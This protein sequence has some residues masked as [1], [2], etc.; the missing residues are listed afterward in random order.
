[1]LAADILKCFPNG[2]FCIFHTAIA[3]LVELEKQREDAGQLG[4]FDA[5][6]Q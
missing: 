4:I 2:G 1:M 6:L 5:Q 3:A